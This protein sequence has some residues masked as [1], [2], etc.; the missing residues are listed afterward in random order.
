MKPHFHPSYKMENRPIMA[1][2]MKRSLHILELPILELSSYLL[3]EI[4]QNPL[5]ELVE[6][7][8]TAAPLPTHKPQEIDFSKS[9][10]QNMEQ[11]HLNYFFP[12]DIYEPKKETT[13]KAKQSLFSY[14]LEQ[15]REVLK[16]E[17]E[18]AIA[19]EIIGNLDERGY[20][21][22]SIEELSLSLNQEREKLEKTLKI[23]KTFE[24]KGIASQNLQECLLSQVEEASLSYKILKNHFSDLLKNK[25]T[26]IQK[27]IKASSIEL[28]KSLKIISHLNFHPVNQF[29]PS[30]P[31]ILITPDAV[32]SE[33]G[34]N[35]IVDVKRDDLP[36]FRINQKYLD[37]FLLSTDLQEKQ[38]FQEHLSSAKLLRKSVYKR[39]HTLKEICIYILKKQI[40]FL[41]SKANLS[42]MSIKEVALVLNLHETTIARAVNNKFVECPRGILP[43]KSFFSQSIKNKEENVSKTSAVDLLKKLIAEEDKKNPLSDLELCKK[44]RD[45]GFV[46]ARRTVTKFRKKNFIGSRFQR[47]KI[48]VEIPT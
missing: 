44:L 47:R 36:S 48:F 27:K 17:E 9:S 43:L 26:L 37:H 20:F 41:K 30:P 5:L 19:E 39:N 14:L 32:I 24:P 38:F 33:E 13:L 21:T 1:R 2:L 42:P 7:S 16:N 12:K 22:I 15:S 4:A 31:Q 11:S 6:S 45:Q 35:W 10:L 29:L 18:L 40:L 23:I 25:I 28:K 34:K 46:I 3:E 8:Q